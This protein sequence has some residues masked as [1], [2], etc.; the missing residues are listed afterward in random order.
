LTTAAAKKD[1]LAQDLAAKT[2]R[3]RQQLA[4]SEKAKQSLNQKIESTILAQIS[5]AKTQ[6]RAAQPT[7]NQPV[8]IAGK[9]APK[10]NLATPTPELPKTNNIAEI[11]RLFLA[12]KGKM[13]APAKGSIV[14]RFGTQAHAEL[15]MVMV[16]NNGVDIKTAPNAAVQA[17]F[18]GQVVS[19]FTIPS[20]GN[21]LMIKHGDYYTT[22]SNLGT[23]AVKRGAWVQAGQN[24]GAVGKEPN[25]GT[26]VL[27]FELW[28]NKLKENPSLWVRL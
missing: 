18:A 19:V 4:Q 24:V 23:I 12:Q 26:Y 22:Y 5:V 27:H 11:N 14:S 10:P 1:K 21:A 16:N 15:P 9:P 6:A 25:T 3:L 2:Q 7:V 8:N 13:P 17:V 28:K 20:M